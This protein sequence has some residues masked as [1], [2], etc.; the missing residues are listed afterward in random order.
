MDGAR[1]TFVVDIP[2]DFEADVRA[3]RSPRLQILVDATAMMQAGI[4]VGYIEAIIDDELARLLGHEQTTGQLAVTLA[5]RA[6]FNQTL[7]STWFTGA[8]AV[9]NNVT[10]LAILLAGAALLREREHGTLEHL[11]AMPV[12]PAEIMIGKILA[13][14]LV[15]LTLSAFAVMVVLEGIL[16]VQIAGSVPL[17]LVGTASYLF[18]ATCLGIFLG[19][20]ARSMPQLG[21]LFIMVALPMIMLSGGNTPLESMPV[22]LQRIMQLSPSTHFV[23]LGQAIL[24]RGAGIA[25]VWPQ[26][27]AILAVGALFFLFSLVRFRSFLAAQQ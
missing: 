13:N 5:L 17:F 23:A 22:W 26:L 25:L 12:R 6:A 15:I 20:V 9:I 27:A 16:R 18:F 1:F 14:G 21:L 4:G 2:P 11:L 8:T 10:M 3:G 24:Y 19:T 7:N